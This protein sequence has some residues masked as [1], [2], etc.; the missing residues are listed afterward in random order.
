M[1]LSHHSI[2]QL[3]N[4]GS[5]VIKPAFEKQN[6]RPVGIRLHLAKDILVPLPNQTV[7]LDIPQQLEYKEIDLTQEA[8]Y[9]EPN[10]FILAATYEEIKTPHN[11]LAILDGRS[12]VARIGLT[13]HITAS[14]ADGTLGMSQAVVLEI[15]NVGNFRVRLKFKDPIAMMI[16]AQLTES[17]DHGAQHQYGNNQKKVTPPILGYTFDQHETL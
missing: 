6:L 15:K 12:T 10:Q 5:L 3:I 14:V 13:T 11:V 17:V 1:L 7:E 2:E 16:F 9:L 8:F 4:E